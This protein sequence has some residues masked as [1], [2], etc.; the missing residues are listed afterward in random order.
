MEIIVPNNLYYAWIAAPNWSTYANR[1]K[2]QYPGLA[3]K[4]TQANS[5]ITLEQV[6]DPEVPAHLEYIQGFG[7]WQ[8]YT[9]GDTITLAKVG[10][11]V[12]FHATPDYTNNF[13]S[14]EYDFHQF[15]M[16]GGIEALGSIN[17]LTNSLGNDYCDAY[18]FCHLFD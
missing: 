17:Y 1:I 7:G 16:S 18:C 12:F 14:S 3:F 5:T 9:V 6:G 15:T 2:M 11:I 13:G 8:P 4:A 10:D